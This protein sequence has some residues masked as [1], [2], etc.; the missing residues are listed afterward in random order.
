MHIWIRGSSAVQAW[1]SFPAFP[2]RLVTVDSSVGHT[3][4]VHEIITYRYR[5]IRVAFAQNSFTLLRLYAV[6]DSIISRVIPR[7]FILG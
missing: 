4:T 1:I 6:G 7:D 2:C 3:L 5:Y